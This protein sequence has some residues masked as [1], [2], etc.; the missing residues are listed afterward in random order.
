[1]GYFFCGTHGSLELVDKI[2][3]LPVQLHVNNNSQGF[4]ESFWVHQRNVGN[5]H[6]VR[7][8]LIDAP[9]ARGC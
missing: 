6:T 7:P 4:P 8:E 1:M 2:Q 9:H 5:Y 3:A